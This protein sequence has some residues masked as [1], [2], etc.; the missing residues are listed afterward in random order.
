M[1]KSNI[2]ITFSFPWTKFNIPK[3][4]IKSPNT[5]RHHRKNRTSCSQ[6]TPTYPKPN[7]VQ[8]YIKT[9]SKWYATSNWWLTYKTVINFYCIS[10]DLIYMVCQHKL[11]MYLK[12]Y[13][14]WCP[15]SNMNKEVKYFG[16]LQFKFI[17]KKIK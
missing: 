15:W 4:L 6:S 7:H 17:L 13:S 3:C 11:I 8:L 14:Q 10:G 5:I 1:F 9:I 2:Y 12:C 16:L